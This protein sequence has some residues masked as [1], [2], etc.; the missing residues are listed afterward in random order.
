MDTVCQVN[1][2][3]HE[4]LVHPIPTCQGTDDRHLEEME[5]MLTEGTWPDG[6]NERAEKGKVPVAGLPLQQWIAKQSAGLG[7]AED[8][9]LASTEV[10][11]IM[12]Q[13][14]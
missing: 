6:D 3:A 1:S 14:H 2:N 8:G 12:C 5:K 7:E 4:W 10:I 13:G 11:N 9:S